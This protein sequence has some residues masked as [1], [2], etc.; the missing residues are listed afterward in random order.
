M[1]DSTV[2][3]DPWENILLGGFIFSLGYRFGAAGQ[4]LSVLWPNM[5]AH[6]PIDPYLGDFLGKSEFRGFLVEFKRNWGERLTEEDKEKLG[7]ISKIAPFSKTVDCHFMGYGYKTS[8]D[9][10]DLKFGN[11]FDLA[12]AKTELD[13]Q[14]YCLDD[15]LQGIVDDRIGAHSEQFRE[16]LGK[17]VELLREQFN[18]GSAAQYKVAKLDSALRGAAILCT[19]DGFCTL[20]FSSFIGFARK[21]GI[22]QSIA[23]DE[24]VTRIRTERRSFNVDEYKQTINKY[25]HKTR[26]SPFD[27]IDEE[28]TSIKI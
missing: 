23:L 19:R 13:M 6:T 28:G 22:A 10:C 7:T 1:S 9:K 21:M 18:S 14:C 5:L 26:K 3:K 11:Y 16:Y 20:P 2:A 12:F 8:I 27:D 24:D 17:L 4:P 25:G 15:F